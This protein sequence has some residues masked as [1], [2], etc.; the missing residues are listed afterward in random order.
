MS[1]DA[2]QASARIE[3]PASLV[4]GRVLLSRV[5]GGGNADLSRLLRLAA[6]ARRTLGRPI[7]LWAV[8]DQNAEL[9]PASAQEALQRTTTSLLNYCDSVTLIVPGSDIHQTL[10]RSTWRGMATLVSRA[11]R[12]RVV[13]DF[14]GAAKVAADPELVT[15]ELERAARDAGILEATS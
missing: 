4:Q 5:V 11:G 14:S 9:P 1:A 2:H 13:E 6:E 10:A 8:I 3:E 12:V 7:L 15:S